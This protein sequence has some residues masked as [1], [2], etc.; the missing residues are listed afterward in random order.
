M[1]ALLIT[2]SATHSLTL[3]SPG[4]PGITFLE[5]V[6][7]NIAPHPYPHP[8]LVFYN[9]LLDL[10]LDVR[11]SMNLKVAGS[12]TIWA[13]VGSSQLH[14]PTG[15]EGQ[16]T[17]GPIGLRCLDLEALSRKTGVDIVDNTVTLT[18]P[19]GQVLE[20]RQC[21][22]GQEEML[23]WRGDMWKAKS[24]LLKSEDKVHGKSEE[25]KNLVGIDYV[26]MSVPVGS[27]GKILSFYENIFKSKTHMVSDGV[28]VVAI[29]G[30]AEDGRC[31]QSLVFRESESV[32]D[33][34]GHHVA[35]YIGGDMEG[36]RT[37]FDQCK[38]RGLVWVNERFSDKVLDWESAVKAQQFRINSI[39]DEEGNLLYKLEHEIRSVEHKDNR[40]DLW[41]TSDVPVEQEAQCASK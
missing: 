9:S 6:N 39:V 21:R 36:F 15:P 3:F 37:V 22:E 24:N 31:C 38:S 29:G 25:D 14:L 13:N 35:L 2:F 10:P 11:K 32:D 26:E 8:D 19:S 41:E 23:T 5:H 40:S 20:V 12:K 33:Y 1:A 7:I 27:A 16:K 34:D 4:S 18:S 17:R 28:G 30:V